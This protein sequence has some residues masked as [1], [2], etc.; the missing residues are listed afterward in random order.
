M[1]KI[2]RNLATQKPDSVDK[3]FK[4]GL[5]Q[6]PQSFY[7]PDLFQFNLYAENAIPNE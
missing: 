6:T 1:K 2:R 7:N 5:V 3:D 4:V